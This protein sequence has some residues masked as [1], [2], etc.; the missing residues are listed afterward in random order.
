[1][2][3]AIWSPR[4]IREFDAYLSWIAERDPG[5]ARRIREEILEWVERLAAHPATGAP[6]SRWPGVFK[7]SWPRR[8]KIV[9]YRL[10]GSHIEI[11]AF[12]DAR[13]DNSNLRFPFD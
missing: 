6:S 7:H 5:A 12:R 9:F 3:A 4:A 8:Q 11:A 1:M 10:F 2:S 13:Q